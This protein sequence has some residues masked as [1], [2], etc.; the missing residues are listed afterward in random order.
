MGKPHDHI[1]RNTSFPAVTGT[2][3]TW[4]G[5]VENDGDGDDENE[6]PVDEDKHKKN[7]IMNMF[8]I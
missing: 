8:K 1:Q 2:G 4:E 7:K 3:A 6:Q 5:G